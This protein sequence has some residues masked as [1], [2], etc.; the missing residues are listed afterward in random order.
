MTKLRDKA[1]SIDLSGIDDPAST[2][3]APAAAVAPLPGN[4]L[5]SGVVRPTTAQPRSGVEAIT[6]SIALRQRAQALEEQ[7]R[8]YEDVPFVELLDP[9]RIRPS[10]FKNR[11]PRAFLTQEFEDLKMEIA[12]VERNVQ[13]I[14]V[15]VVGHDEAGPI[16]ELVYG[17]R[18]HRA[19]ADLNLKVA[20]IVVHNMSDQDAFIEADKENQQQKNLSPWEQGV[21]YKDALDSGLF[22][23]LRRLASVLGVDP[24][25]MSRAMAIAGLPEVVIGAFQS[26]LEIQFRWGAALVEAV[27]KDPAQITSVAKEIQQTSPRPPADKVFEKL[28]GAKHAVADQPIEFKVGGKTYGSWVKDKKGNVTFKLRAGGLD[29]KKEEKLLSF[30]KSLME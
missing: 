27:E 17:R 14:K 9:A 15:R 19:C 11:D 23:S 13:P 6:G 1:A 29:K 28:V 26:P 3:K 18:R 22:P 21:K 30:I 5:D 4:L 20:A 25:N 10:K 16:Y 24:G 8:K 12:A 7:L 2:E